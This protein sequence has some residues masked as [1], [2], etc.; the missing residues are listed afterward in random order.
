MVTDSRPSAFDVPRVNGFH[1]NVPSFGR[2][3]TMQYNSG[4][5]THALD[6]GLALSCSRVL[7]PSRV[8]RVCVISKRDSKRNY[9][10]PPS[11]LGSL[12]KSIV[13]PPTTKI[14]SSDKEL[15]PNQ[16][17]TKQVIKTTEPMI[18]V[19]QLR[20]NRS[21]IV[22]PFCVGRAGAKCRGTFY[23]SASPTKRW[24]R[25]RQPPTK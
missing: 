3:G 5:F 7:R 22:C 23:K 13:N 20:N 12:R 15:L 8:C 11:V 25:L 6:R 21:I 9:F 4:E 19:F 16:T 10:S 14:P 18:V 2:C 1:V 17:N 24:R